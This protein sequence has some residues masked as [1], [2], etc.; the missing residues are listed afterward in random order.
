MSLK[1][2]WDLCL[3][4]VLKCLEAS[5]QKSLEARPS[6]KF[7]F[8]HLFKH[9]SFFQRHPVNRCWDILKLWHLLQNLLQL[10]SSP[11]QKVYET[12]RSTPRDA[13]EYEN[14]TG[15][16]CYLVTK[17]CFSR[18]WK[19]QG[20]VWTFNFFSTLMASLTDW[21]TDWPWLAT[22]RVAFD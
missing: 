1:K 14:K 11:K 9:K 12:F 19:G 4:L 8:K 7:K 5:D 13:V 3:E 22:S 17:V 6:F 18:F 10:P 16:K 2:K 15:P 21:L 20:F